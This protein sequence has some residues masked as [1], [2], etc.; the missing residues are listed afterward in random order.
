MTLHPYTFTLFRP[1]SRQIA[2]DRH[3]YPS[4]FA[5]RSLTAT[6]RAPLGAHGPSPIISRPRALGAQLVVAGTRKGV[7]FIPATI[8]R[9]FR[10][11]NPSPRSQCQRQVCLR[12]GTLGETTPANIVRSLVDR[13]RSSTTQ[14]SAPKTDCPALNSGGRDTAA[15][16]YPGH[17]SPMLSLGNQRQCVNSKLVRSANSAKQPCG[18]STVLLRS[19]SSGP[20]SIIGWVHS[21]WWRS[22]PLAAPYDHKPPALP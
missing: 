9:C 5:L 13:Q 11:R 14:V 17:P 3:P 18:S 20:L 22:P 2:T 15:K 8:R 4:P 7:Q 6:L 16:P 21:S 10:W 19:C 12:A 1:V